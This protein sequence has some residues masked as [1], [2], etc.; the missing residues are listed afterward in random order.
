MT[1]KYSIEVLKAALDQ[2]VTDG[3]FHPPA[4]ELEQSNTLSSLDNL[5]VAAMAVHRELEKHKEDRLKPIQVTDAS[6]MPWPD[7]VLYIAMADQPTQEMVS[8][9]LL[10]EFWGE[11]F[12]FIGAPPDEWVSEL[13]ATGHRV[14]ELP[15]GTAINTGRRAI[16]PR[17]SSMGVRWLEVKVGE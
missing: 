3:L 15:V 5:L 6:E 16:T 7:D 1:H 12:C 13:V 9:I 14:Y 4:G 2:G 10:R 11:E 8:R 17:Q